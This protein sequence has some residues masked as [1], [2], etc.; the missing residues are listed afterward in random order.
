MRG[1]RTENCVLLAKSDLSG[2]RHECRYLLNFIFFLMV[3]LK[4]KNQKKNP[5]WATDGNILF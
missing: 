3:N 5:S 1:E 4:K 2:E